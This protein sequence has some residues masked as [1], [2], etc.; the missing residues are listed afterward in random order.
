MGE[1]KSIA[2]RPKRGRLLAR[3]HRNATP[4]PRTGLVAL[5][6]SLS[7]LVTTTS[8]AGTGVTIEAVDDFHGACNP[9]NY[10]IENAQ[11][12]REPLVNAGAFTEGATWFDPDMWRADFVE[13]S[14]SY[15]F[16]REG[17]VDAI[18][19]VSTHGNCDD[20]TN[21]TCT[22]SSTCTNPPQWRSLPGV[23]LPQGYIVDWGYWGTCVYNYR[24]S[25]Y[26][27]NC[28]EIDY[29]TGVR[30]GE[31]GS[32]GNWAGA[33]TNGGANFV[34]I[35][36]SCGVRPGLWLEGTQLMFAGMNTVALV[37][38]HRGWGDDNW[39]NDQRGAAFAAR[40]SNNPNSS[41]AWS[42]RDA[43]N[44][45]DAG[46]GAPCTLPG[47][48]G[49]H[50]IKGCGSHFTMSADID[51]GWADWAATAET[52]NDVRADWADSWGRNCYKGYIMCNYNC[53]VNPLTL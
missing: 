51:C 13:S 52:W 39:D 53:S 9:T 50:G 12:F 33:G 7:L 24:R 23:C 47:G 8:H 27:Q 6:A 34:V 49:G 40:Y 4:R 38:V 2:A 43:I 45:I 48:G 36:N 31:S 20:T 41:I 5:G 22:S 11:K 37:A 3:V 10:R 16:D 17:N 25:I 30:W 15:G 32:S 46:I 42:W 14:D 28:T 19:F 44:T 29:S 35:D 1:L 26:L 18:A 21:D